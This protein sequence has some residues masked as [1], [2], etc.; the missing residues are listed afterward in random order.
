MKEYQSFQD[1][2]GSD[3]P[4]E[5]SK[6]RF[7][8]LFNDVDGRVMMLATRAAMSVTLAESGAPHC[9]LGLDV[10]NAKRLRLTCLQPPT[11]PLT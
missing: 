9:R 11:H 4:L 2:Y 3:Y 8:Q 1:E 5:N 10:N 6:T 7:E